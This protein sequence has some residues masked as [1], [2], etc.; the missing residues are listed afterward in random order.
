M[1]ADER[2]AHARHI[3]H[4]SM[5]DQHTRELLAQMRRHGDQIAQ[6]A[7]ER[8]VDAWRGVTTSSGGPNSAP[9]AEAA[10]RI[11]GLIFDGY[12]RLGPVVAL[13]VITGEPGLI[14]D[15]IAW[16]RRGLGA[17]VMPPGVPGWEARLLEAYTA[18]CCEVLPAEDCVAV[19]ETIERA[20][21]TLAPA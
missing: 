10:E 18:A 7:A 12:R 14:V 2:I 3:Q 5:T 21:S 6:S 8:I 17:R 9:A 4:I 1:P 11:A 19:R 15:D 13:S 20:I 16:L